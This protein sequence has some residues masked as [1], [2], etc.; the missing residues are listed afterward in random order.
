MFKRKK[1]T[2]YYAGLEVPP[3][4]SVD[5]Y[6]CLDDATKGVLQ[7]ASGRIAF[8]M[9]VFSCC[10]LVIVGK[11]FYMTVLSYQ[12]RTFTPSV[13]KMDLNIARHNILDRN[14]MILA[15]SVP[16]KDLSINPKE[17]KPKD[18]LIVAENLSKVLPGVSKED[19]LKKITQGGSFRY[20][21]RNITPVEQKD[22]NWLG[23]YFL[24][25]TDGEKRVYP[26]GS[27]FAHLLGSVDIDN[28]GTAGLEKSYEKELQENDLTLSL[29]ISVQEMVARVLSENIQK[30]RALGGT[31]IVMDVQTGEVLASV[32]LPDYN[33]NIAKEAD[34]DARFNKATLGAYEFG[35]VFKLFN[36]AMA[37]ENKVI[38]PHDVFDAT[39]SFKIGRKTIEDYRGQK[40]P[41]M[42]PEILIHSSN[43]G[44]VRIALKAGYEK[45]KEF[46]SRF[47]FYNPLPIQLPEKTRTQY[48]TA[49]KW[50]DMTSA[51]ISYGYG[52][53]VSPLHLISAVSAL[54]NG[55]YYRVPTF[56]KD[57]NKGKAEYQVI[58]QKVSEQI[59]H[60]MWGVINWN[61]KD[62]NPV[63]KYHVGGKT[64]SA[65]M[66]VNGT[67]T[68]GTLRTTF[69]CAFPM[70]QPKYAVLVVL[71][72]PKK[73]GDDFAN[74]AGWNAKPTGLQIVTEI[75]SYLGV[76]AQ[77]EW[78]QPSYMKKS[79]ELSQE[80]DK[81]RR[82]R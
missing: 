55:G 63:K 52:I 34:S 57:G 13:L 76:A 79:I 53:A 40:R 43:I 36:T 20:I 39:N 47:G 54:V 7:K 72:N 62:T 4:T 14:G 41:L 35:S 73:W 80:A 28:K 71:E 5:R 51:T 3:L 70:N 75:A 48:P 6:K 15:T 66:L 25:E 42:V 31:S 32:S 33:P 12:S 74:T 68:E 24:E 58:S 81:K 64:G 29:D 61:M 77:P 18:R 65:E 49:S 37:L 16:T 45:Q 23:Y 60:M 8:L 38:R 30:Y 67:Y 82:R 19:V 2:F 69:V 44:S 50:G 26:Q 22:V 17:V 78:I 56:I 27:L 46:L 59:R 11:L 1:E 10:F 21:K 9:F